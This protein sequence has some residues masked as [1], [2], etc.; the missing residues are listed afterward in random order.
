MITD[1]HSTDVQKC[2][3]GTGEARREKR[4][5]ALQAPRSSNTCIIME[6]E[7]EK[8]KSWN[9]NRNRRTDRRAASL[10]HIP[11]QAG[12]QPPT[13]WPSWRWRWSTWSDRHTCRWKDYVRDIYCNICDRRNQRRRQTC[14]SCCV[15]SAH[16]ID[17]VSIKGC[18]SA[19][20]SGE[21]TTVCKF[22]LLFVLVL[23]DVFVGGGE[24]VSG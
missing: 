10:P 11:S 9:R 5:D 6:M 12:P 22:G 8:N 2:N 4:L 15:Q 1:Q 24:W 20:S 21:T 14:P 13:L 18:S 16:S 19:I 3:V 23:K 17:D 7:K